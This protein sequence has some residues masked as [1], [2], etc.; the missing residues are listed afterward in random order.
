MWSWISGN[1]EYLSLYHQYYEELITN[2][3]TSGKFET[4]IERVYEMILPYVQSDASAFYSVDEF[5]TGYETLKQ[6]CLLRAESIE[7]QLNGELASVSSEQNS[8][9]FVDATA[10][11]ISDMGSHGLAMNQ[12]SN[13]L[14]NK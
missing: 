3:F 4:E 6:F 14:L 13:I 12:E 9:D 5:K 2:Y 7:K 11:N 8:E 1:E 10:I